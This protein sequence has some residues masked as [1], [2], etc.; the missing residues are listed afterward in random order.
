MNVLD[1]LNMA[2]KVLLNINMIGSSFMFKQ[3]KCVKYCNMYLNQAIQSCSK[4]KSL[5]LSHYHWKFEF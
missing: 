4:N 2:W 1:F 5:L 3:K